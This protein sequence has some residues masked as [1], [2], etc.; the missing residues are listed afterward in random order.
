MYPAQSA[1]SSESVEVE[2]A[3]LAATMT[4]EGE[5][6]AEE[7]GRVEDDEEGAGEEE[8]EGGCD[9]TTGAAE[10]ETGR[11]EDVATRD[12]VTI[13][14]GDPVVAATLAGVLL[15]VLERIFG[16]ATTVVS[17][18]FPPLNPAK[19]FTSSPSS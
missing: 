18:L 6:A 9:E 15:A 10:E 4:G 8:E 7:A 5:A 17:A 19:A 13:A 11:A 12:R 14:T 16:F 2:E 1:P 3:G